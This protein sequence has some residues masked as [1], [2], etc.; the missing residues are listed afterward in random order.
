M[1]IRTT[2]MTILAILTLLGSM[3]PVRA[4]STDGD[5]PLAGADD[6]TLRPGDVIS[7]SIWPNG[8]LG[9]DFTVEES[10]YVYLPLLEEVRAAG[11]PIGEL[12]ENLRRGYRDAMQN[13]VVTVRPSYRITITGEVQRPGIH[14]ISPT[15][16]LLDVVGMAGG[17]RSAAD[18]ERVRVVR[19]GEVV[20]FDALRALET[21]AGMDVIR[22]R[23]GDHIVVPTARPPRLTWSTAFTA[24]RTVSTL[25]LIW[26]RLLR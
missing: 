15:H 22:L 23:S 3:E 9:G 16:S 6:V 2:A 8:E 25:L 13:P 7:I 4:Q 19:E 20:T 12:R 18:M 24:V 26:D 11:V 5:S 10:G 1:T 21:G 14:V 17:F